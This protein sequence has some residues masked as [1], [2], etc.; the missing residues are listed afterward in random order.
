MV[1][2]YLSALRLAHRTTMFPAY[3]TPLTFL[4]RA[5]R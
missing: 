3:A 4:R 2:K 1:G 5:L